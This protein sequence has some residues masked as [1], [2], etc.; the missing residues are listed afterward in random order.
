MRALDG[1]G[2]GSERWQYHDAMCEVLRGQILIRYE[3]EFWMS[4]MDRHIDIW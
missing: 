1:D 4:E 2:G 3:Y